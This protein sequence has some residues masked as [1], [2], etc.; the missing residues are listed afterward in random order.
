MRNNALVAVVALAAALAS[1]KRAPEEPQAPQQPSLNLAAPAPSSTMV[2]NP[3]SRATT[4]YTNEMQAAYLQ[5]QA[6]ALGIA[7]LTKVTHLGSEAEGAPAMVSPEEGLART[8]ELE[9][10]FA[11][12]RRAIDRGKPK[13]IDLSGATPQLLQP[14]EPAAG[15]AP[16]P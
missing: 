8:R 15:G 14:R 13:T 1:C 9:H 4:G 7:R 16:T 5:D 2:T 10:E 6:A 11:A 3:L 12:Q